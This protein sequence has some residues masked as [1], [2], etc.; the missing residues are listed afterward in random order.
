MIELKV[1]KLRED[2]ILPTRGSNESAGL[3]DIRGRIHKRSSKL[4]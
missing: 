3:D 2:A 1:Q 4:W